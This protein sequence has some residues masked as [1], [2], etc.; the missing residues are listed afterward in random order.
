MLRAIAPT[1]TKATISSVTSR[2]RVSR[3]IDKRPMKGQ[4]ISS[5]TVKTFR[6]DIIQFL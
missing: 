6:L 4:N 5:K 2:K 1:R 3:P